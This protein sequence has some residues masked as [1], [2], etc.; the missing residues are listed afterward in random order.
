MIYVTSDLHFCHNKDFIYE[1]RGFDSV[2][3]MNEAIVRRW[4][5]VVS[6]EDEVYVLGDLMLNDDVEGVRLINSLNRKSLF[7]V[8]GNH[9]TASRTTKYST[10]KKFAG[11]DNA[12]Y[13][14]YGSYHFYLSHYPT[15][16][17]NFDHDKPLKSRLINLCGHSHVTDSFEDWDWYDAPI[18]HCELD[19]HNCYPVS[20][21]EIIEHIKNHKLTMNTVMERF[22]NSKV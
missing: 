8:R 19:A 16:T 20:I 11:I 18:Y 1:A 22:K 5:T 21:E 9:D 4:N 15:L 17:S 14:N 2:E 13:L 6:N 3:E 12:M 10:L 7:I